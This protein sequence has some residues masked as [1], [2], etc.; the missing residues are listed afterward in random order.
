M[1]VGGYGYLGQRMLERDLEGW[2]GGRREQ[3]PGA[4]EPVQRPRTARVRQ[5]G[6]QRHWWLSLVVAQ[7]RAAL[8]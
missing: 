1:M 2:T 6:G 8:R 3:G 5:T 4:D 7:V